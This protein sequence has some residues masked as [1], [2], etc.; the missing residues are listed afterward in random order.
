[1]RK[2]IK[3]NKTKKYLKISGEF[4][5][6]VLAYL[7]FYL[8]KYLVPINVAS[9]CG[10]FIGKYILASIP[11]QRRKEVIKNIML[12]FPNLN[13][14]EASVLYKNSCAN[15]VQVVFEIPKV[16]AIAKHKTKYIVKDEYGALEKMANDKCLL[17]TAHIGN[18]ELAG[19][20]LLNKPNLDTQSINVI[21]KAPNNSYLK[22]LFSKLRAATNTTTMTLN[23]KSLLLLNQKAKTKPFTI[24]MLVDQRIKEG[25]KSVTFFNRKAPTTPLLP[26]F[27]LKYNIPL[28]P[29]RVIRKENKT[30]EIVYEKPIEY[31]ATGNYEQDLKTLTQ[32]MNNHVEGWVKEYPE[33]WFWLHRRW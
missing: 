29:L 12:A 13:A 8:V 16:E 14:K 22:K 2:K 18:W 15:F 31:Q 7:L 30:Y 23:R 27:A 28:V 10:H 1:M 19:F 24:Y 11:L 33:Q 20:S 32:L 6:A 26:M 25:L 21:Y 9:S 4:T 17:F 5:L 3:H